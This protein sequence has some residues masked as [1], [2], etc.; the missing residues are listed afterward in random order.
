[1][2]QAI[3]EAQERLL[4]KRAEHGV[5]ELPTPLTLNVDEFKCPELREEGP[6]ER[7]KHGFPLERFC[8]DC[9][10]EEQD[11]RS[12]SEHKAKYSKIL[13]DSANALAEFNVPKKYR[14]CSF[15]SYI[16][17]DKA[18]EACRRYDSGGLVIFGNTGCG[19]THLSVSIMREK[20]QKDLKWLIEKEWKLG[21]YYGLEKQ[22]FQTVPDLL[23]EIRGTFADGPGETE[24][25]IIDRY[26]NIPFLVLDDLGSEKTS[27][28]AITTLYIIID[29]RDR[30]ELSTVITTNLS[31]SEIE[32]KLSARIASRLSGWKN[33]KINMPDFRKKRA[34]P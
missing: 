8:L 26:S 34:S 23:L 19:K 10:R 6:V 1:M 21:C 17:N 20:L 32:E 22:R 18:V 28:F 2:D 31:L 7:C 33:I 14:G 24:Q 3:Q 13:E 4:R 15:S 29:R 11:L 30:E 27:E 12:I 16:G 9:N 25:G 5:M